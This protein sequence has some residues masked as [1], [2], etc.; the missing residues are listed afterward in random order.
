MPPITINTDG[1]TDDQKKSPK[2]RFVHDGMLADLSIPGFI[3]VLCA[4]EAAHKLFLEMNG[5][6]KFI[7][8][9]AKVKYD[10]VADNFVGDLA[11]VRPVDAPAP[12]LSKLKDW[13]ATMALCY[14]AGGV[15][16]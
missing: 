9:P 15:V 4:H 1:I 11:A 8:L 7:Y 3:D 14:A 10:P 5:V 13:V 6:T 2:F 16:S 12:D